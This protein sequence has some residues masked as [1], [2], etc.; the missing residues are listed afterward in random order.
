MVDPEMNSK[1]SKTVKSVS[2][3]SEIEDRISSRRA[4]F[5]ARKRNAESS[6]RRD[7]IAEAR[8]DLH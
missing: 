8:P 7:S 5:W 4:R 6:L 1:S 3:S 2:P